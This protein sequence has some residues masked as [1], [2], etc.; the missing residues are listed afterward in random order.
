M[1]AAI[2]PGHLPLRCR[3]TVVGDGSQYRAL[4]AAAD[5]LGVAASFPGRIPHSELPAVYAAHD[6]FVLASSLEACSNAVLEAMASGLP[7]IG[8]ASAVGDLV[9]DGVCGMLAGGSGTDELAEA[10]ARLVAV[11]S[12]IPSMRAAAR[13]VAA[14][15]SPERLIAGYQE[16][17]RLARRGRGG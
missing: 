2:A 7:V 3:L 15:H 10:I 9:A 16:V 17:I 8:A 12:R 6:A 5:S 11:P 1:L 14:E 13:L 4:A